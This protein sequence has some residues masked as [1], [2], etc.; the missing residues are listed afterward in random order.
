MGL[1]HSTHR[2]AEI[3]EVNTSAPCVSLAYCALGKQTQIWDSKR[4]RE[5]DRMGK[6]KMLGG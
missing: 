3:T 4:D 2:C 6:E 5:Q 1:A